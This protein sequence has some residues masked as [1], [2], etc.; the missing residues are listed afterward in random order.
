[1]GNVKNKSF[2]SRLNRDAHY[3]GLKP[4]ARDNPLYG[5]TQASES[6]TKDEGVWRAW[7]ARARDEGGGRGAKASRTVAVGWVFF[8]ATES[9]HTVL[10][11]EALARDNPIYGDGR[12]RPRAER[13]T[14]DTGLLWG[15][16]G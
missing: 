1:M 16:W 14:K 6:R 10:R 12:K 2:L 5:R 4:F 3:W 7:N 15:E 13:R 9:R 8:V 11:A